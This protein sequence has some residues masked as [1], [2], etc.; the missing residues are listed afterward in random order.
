[1]LRVLCSREPVLLSL[2]QGE[3]VASLQ[4]LNF[5]YHGLPSSL[6]AYWL[7]PR[8]AAAKSQVFI[9]LS[10]RVLKA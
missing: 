6:C 4:A 3:E 5:L 1:M 10:T 2:I 7:V 9:A 8:E